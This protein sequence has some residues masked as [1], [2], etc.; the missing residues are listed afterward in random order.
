[1][2]SDTAV[3]FDRSCFHRILMSVFGLLLL[4]TAVAHA[5]NPGTIEDAYHG[6]ES[7][8][9][10]WECRSTEECSELQ[11]SSLLGPG[12][13]CEG[14]SVQKNG[15]DGPWKYYTSH[16]T[17]RTYAQCDWGTGGAGTNFGKLWYWYMPL[18]AECDNGSGAPFCEHTGDEYYAELPPEPASAGCNETNPCNPSDGNK[19]QIEEDYQSPA[20]GGLS[21]SRYYNS[22][23]SY[24]TDATM[25]LGW[26]HSYSRSIDEPPE[27]KRKYAVKKTDEQSTF[28]STASDACTNGWDEIKTIAWGGDLSGATPT[29]KGGNVCQLTS[30]GLV[31]GEFPVRSAAGFPGFLPPLGVKTVVR[32]NGKTY[33]FES[34]GSGWLSNLHP[35]VSLVESG[36]DWIFTDTNDTEETY[37]GSGQLIE[38]RNRNGQT[39]TLEYT[40]TAAQGGDD[41]STTLDRVTGPFGHE[42]TLAYTS[43]RLGSVTTPDGT[44]TYAY[45]AA[46]NLELVTYPDL[47][48][49]KYHYSDLVVS[50]YPGQ[51]T[52]ITDENGVLFASWEYDLD[53]RAIVSE[54]AGGKERVELD[55]NTD[56]TTTLTMA[57]GSSRTYTFGVEQG[58]RKPTSLSGDVCSTCAGGN[59][60]DRDYDANGFLSE[61]TDWEGNVTQMVKNSR[62]LTEALVEAFGTVEQ[63]TTTTTWHA[64]YRLPTTV[65]TPINITTDTHDTD[66]NVLTRTIAGG[67]KSRGWVFSYTADGQ[68]WTID[69]PRTDVADVTTLEYYVCTTG[70]ECGQL[71]KV[72]NA[73]GHVTDYNTY[74]SA[75]RLTKMTGPNGLETT[76][77]YDLRGRALTVT[78]TPTA[79]TARTTIMTYDDVGQLKTLT[80]PDGRVVTYDYTDARYLDSVTDSDGNKIEYDYD[81]MGNLLSEETYDPSSV[82]TRALSYTRDLNYRL[83]LVSDGPITSDLG[84]DLVGNL[85]TEQDGNLNLTQHNYDAL[86]RLDD[87]LNALSGIVDYDYDD[88]DNLKQVVAAN[89]ATT[90]YVYDALDNL[91]SETSPDRGLTTYTHDD[92][93]N[94][95]TK[96]DARGIT[97]T[98]TYDAL[99]RLKTV[100]YPTVAEN[101]TYNYDNAAVEGI[102]RLTSMSDESGSTAYVYN[103]FGEVITDQRTIDGQAY[104]TNYAHDAAGRID[105]ITYPSG[106]VVDYN[107]N[108]LGEITAVDS[109]K[110]GTNKS[111][112]S[113]AS[114]EPFGPVNALTYGNGLSFDYG[115]RTN[116]SLESYESAGVIENVYAFDA[117]GRIKIIAESEQSQIAIYGYDALNR[118]TQES[119]SIGY[120]D[121]VLANNPLF[122]WKLDDTSGPT[123]ID[124]SGN[125]INGTYGSN[126]NYGEDGLLPGSSSAIRV[127]PPNANSYVFSS[128]LN[129]V[130]LTGLELWFQ[131]DST[132]DNRQMISIRSAGHS[133]FILHQ[134]SSGQI[135]VWWQGSVVFYSDSAVALQTPHHVA[136]WYESTPNLT[137]MMID[138][139]IQSNTY[140]GNLFAITNPDVI[141][142]AYSW[143]WA[144]RSTMLGEL[145]E[146]A[147]YSNPVDA[148]TFSGRDSVQSGTS[149]SFDYTYDANG[150][151]DT[152][153]DGT[154]TVNYSISS[155]S[156]NLTAIGGSPIGRDAAGNRV[157]DMAGVRTF[158]YSDSG[159]LERV[160]MASV[161]MGSYVYN[162]HGQRTKKDTGTDEIVYLYDLDGSLLAEYTSAGVHIRDYVW[163]D[164]APVAQIEA[165]EVFRYLHYDHLGTPRLA[166]DDSQIVIWRWDSDAFG[167]IAANDDPDG[168]ST[169]TT[170]NLR[171]PGQYFDFESGLHYNYHRTYDPSTGRYLESDPIGLSGGLNTYGY[172]YQNPSLF[173]DPDGLNPLLK[174]PVQRHVYGHLSRGNISEVRHTLNQLGHLTKQESRNLAQQC[175]SARK[176]NLLQELKDS[177]LGKGARSGQHGTPAKRAGAQMIR[178]GNQLPPGPYQDAFKKAGKQLIDQGKGVNH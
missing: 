105:S 83:D 86:N 118:V 176:K 1:M 24:K 178:E 168:D 76:Y 147:V 114:H 156:N 143:H 146:V 158:A 28:Y 35:E 128:D 104:N 11:A 41:D 74:D 33:R 164:S 177:G 110:G 148:S 119:T 162:G 14:Y 121:L 8:G 174:D 27:R 32:P 165:G 111:I 73:L 25:S 97:A 47:A 113:S 175:A 163:M 150:N 130:N 170:V 161:T 12:G 172:A 106:R 67:G 46:E 112:I 45:D 70:S 138:G 77:S 18:S 17:I 132:T 7:G 94:V 137:Y 55:Y 75:G 160:D 30:G 155:N 68:V 102:G 22:L 31:V 36:S 3:K 139:V 40:L 85:T 152:I 171:F 37:N 87:T 58:Q 96:T 166:T 15:T 43:G 6:H 173:V 66:G 9:Q 93:G 44:I 39:E 50:G 125:S 159:R 135:A 34:N 151:R 26:R 167:S 89:G 16:W 20:A 79:G 69:G 10:I 51:L 124:S 149:A 13:H 59:I 133:K 126:I 141:V 127:D 140:S 91:L 42:I 62:G 56:G 169:V 4:F 92:A 131:T 117:A 84:F 60:R 99:N 82:L 95:L 144:I 90:D 64:D 63:R 145:D 29:F 100:S 2:F 98:Y 48:T 136:V 54:H 157:S 134:R 71:K 123:A 116:Y 78:E 153:D 57:N 129:G 109:A 38:I 19:S 154:T 5:H 101:V 53:G 108:A 80:L 23:G 72:T 49:R 103:E 122:Y 142:G 81:E 120:S 21:F 65:T 107:R 61:V 88:H 115:F 52:G